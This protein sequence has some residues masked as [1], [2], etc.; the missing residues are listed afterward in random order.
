MRSSTTPPACGAA[1]RVLGLAR[2]DPVEVG[3]EAAV[4]ERRRARPGDGE[5]AQVAD[6]EHA[7]ARAHRGVLGD[8]AGRVGDRHRPAAE[9]TQGRPERDVPVV[10]RARQEIGRIGHAAHGTAAGQLRLAHRN[11]P[12]R[13]PERIPDSRT[14]RSPTR[15]PECPDSRTECPDSR[16]GAGGAGGAAAQEGGEDPAGGEGRG[17]DQH[18]GERQ[19]HGEREAR[20]P[21]RARPSRPASCARTGGSRS[22][23]RL[24]TA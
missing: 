17:G 18:L 20:R 23:A 10:Q 4:H 2:A 12:T 13:A 11:V 19:Q 21:A 24:I 7:D 15:A 8:G 3:G 16:S 5:L 1:Q 14:E 6:V 9:R 22:A